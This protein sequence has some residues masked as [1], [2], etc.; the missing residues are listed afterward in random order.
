MEILH[1]TATDVVA[2]HEASMERPVGV[3]S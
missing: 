1:R 3:R 2:S